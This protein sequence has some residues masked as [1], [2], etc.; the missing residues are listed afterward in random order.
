MDSWEDLTGFINLENIGWSDLEFKNHRL[1]ELQ[2]AILNEFI[3]RYDAKI[4]DKIID[5]HFDIYIDISSNGWYDPGVRSGPVEN[6]YPPEGED[7]RT[8]TNYSI[9]LSEDGDDNISIDAEDTSD[10][11]IASLLELLFDKNIQC[12]DCV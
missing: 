4:A 5:G 7:I 8:I 10:D 3:K 1:Y 11:D 6:C 9:V 2:I 12:C